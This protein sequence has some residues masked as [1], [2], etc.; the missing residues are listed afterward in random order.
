MNADFITLINK[1]KHD[2]AKIEE[3]RIYILNNVYKINDI[4]K[5]I[6]LF[7]NK[8][9]EINDDVGIALSYGMYFW[10]YHSVDIKKA[11]DYNKKSLELYKKIENY[12]NKCGYLSILNN[13]FIYDNYTGKMNDACDIMNEAMS[14]ALEKTDIKYYFVFSVNSIYLLLDL[15]LY[16]KALNVLNKIYENDIYLSNID[17]A[18]LTSLKIKIYINL[19]KKNEALNEALNLL[20]QN[21]NERVFDD[22]IICSNLIIVYL[23]NNNL[24]EADKYKNLLD[25]A[26][27]KINDEIDLVEAYLAYAKYYSYKHDNI[28]AYNYYLRCLNNYN[29]M[30]G[31]KINAISEA[32]EIFKYQDEKTYYKALEIKNNLLEECNKAYKKMYQ[33]DSEK[34]NC[35]YNLKYKYVFE[36]IDKIT[37]FIKLM[38]ESNPTNL[39]NIITDNIKKIT[40]AA[41]VEMYLNYKQDKIHKIDISKMNDIEI[42]TKDKL[43]SSNNY[44]F[45]V[46]TKIV[47]NDEYNYW[48]LA[49]T[50]KSNIEQKE[51][52][53]LIKLLKE[54]CYPVFENINKYYKALDKSNH[55]QLTNLYNRYGLYE[56]LKNHFNNDLESYLIEIDVDNFKKIN[57]TYGHDCGDL[58][59]IKLSEILI[60]H[61]SPQNAF[62]IG[63]EE[64]I[65]IADTSNV[66]QLLDN[67]QQEINN[68]YID[69][70]NNKLHF[71]I[72]VGATK[73][74]S[75]N[76]LPSSI[77]RA[78][79]LLYKAKQTGKNKYYIEN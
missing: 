72:S 63:G 35:F 39:E 40:N 36:N 48:Y 65:C 53:Y 19:N 6:D 34:F 64:F 41:N 24:N 57:D 37:R 78:D 43:E 28:K 16:D 42:I 49:F 47:H 32:T 15:K 11:H 27:I 45:V 58:V 29:H 66:K 38:N 10:I 52:L 79:I 76:D 8:A 14:L 56:I 44:D 17:K 51:T 33:A 68:F 62:R 50:N 77:K 25:E 55:D 67:L 2:K 12:Q 4:T 74:Y 23:L 69:Y 60:K 26:I 54:I 1:Y 5:Y 31:Y 46:I 71:T 70:N 21:K 75:Y 9:L 3:I 7:Y 18:I 59:L 61:F 73:I 13:E 30:L 20:N 22:Y